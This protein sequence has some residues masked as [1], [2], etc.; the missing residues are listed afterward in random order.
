MSA[1]YVVTVCYRFALCITS[2]T[3]LAA[4][5]QVGTRF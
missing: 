3:F 5:L 2:V 1:L 4:A